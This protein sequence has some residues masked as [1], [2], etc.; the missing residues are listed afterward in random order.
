MV[1]QTDGSMSVEFVPIADNPHILAAKGS[2]ILDLGTVSY[3]DRSKNGIEIVRKTGDFDVAT[4]IGM[5]IGG[6]NSSG[7]T[8][9][10]KAWLAA[11]ASPYRI[12]FDGIELNSQPV[13][14]DS[15]MPL[16]VSTQHQLKIRVPN[17]SLGEQANLQAVISMQ[18]VLN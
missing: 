18:A 9:L 5:R 15:T 3:A 11:P 8:V 13:C 10:L 12:F 1:V 14:V 4:P 17:K 6:G 16:G 7:E 2:A